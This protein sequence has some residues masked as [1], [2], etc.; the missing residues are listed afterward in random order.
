MMILEWV[1]K[2]NSVL[3]SAAETGSAVNGEVTVIHLGG[4]LLR[5]LK[6]PTRRS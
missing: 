1:C 4:G 3:A 6:Q 2:P 5:A